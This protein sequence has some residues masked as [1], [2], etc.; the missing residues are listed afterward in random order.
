MAEPLK[1][2]IE[3]PLEYLHRKYAQR[4][5]AGI[6]MVINDEFKWRWRKNENYWL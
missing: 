5:N 4:A 6:G 1:L 3:K 2:P